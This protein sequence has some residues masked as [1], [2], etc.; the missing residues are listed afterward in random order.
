VAVNW[1]AVGRTFAQGDFNYD[2]RVDLR[3]L[4]I[5]AARWQYTLPS[6]ALPLPAIPATL[7]L[8]PTRRTA[9]RVITQI[10]PSP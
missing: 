2:G 3:D 6:P 4:N 5:L 9:T 10:Q 7:T 8:F 1:Q